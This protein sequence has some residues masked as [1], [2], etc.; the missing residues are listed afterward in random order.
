MRIHFLLLAVLGLTGCDTLFGNPTYLPAGYTYHNDL[1]KAPP[2]PAAPDIGYSYNALRN[3]EILQGWEVAAQ[4]LVAQLG[5]NGVGPQIVYLETLV[6]NDA[7]TASYDNS[8][9]D[10][11][12]ARGYLLETDP[13]T[14]V[15]IRYDA[16]LPVQEEAMDATVDE[17]ADDAADF[18]LVLTVRSP[19]G[20]MQVSGVYRLPDYGYKKNLFNAPTADLVIG[21]GR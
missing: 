7:F 19:D 3:R 14:P 21:G 11:L 4:D 18:I 8:L 6:K 12:R 17:A 15:H 1:Y 5:D 10:E 16:Y 20:E 9:R 13:A 2:G